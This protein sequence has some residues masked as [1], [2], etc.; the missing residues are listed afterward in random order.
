MADPKAAER[1][2]QEGGTG[3]VQGRSEKGGRGPAFPAQK[4]GI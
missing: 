2:G 1:M 4:L 3:T